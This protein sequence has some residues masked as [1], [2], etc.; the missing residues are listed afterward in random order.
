MTN[1]ASLQGSE[2]GWRVDEFPRVLADAVQHGL[3]CVGG[4]FQFRLPEGATCEMYWLCADA[5]PKR[6][7]ET[8][9]AYVA[10]CHTE[11]GQMFSRLCAETDFRREAATGFKFLREKCDAGFDPLPHLYFIAYFDHEPSVA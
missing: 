6:E 10:R 4:Q 1:G 8:W 7:S 5:S 11:V 3:A 9:S 2:Y